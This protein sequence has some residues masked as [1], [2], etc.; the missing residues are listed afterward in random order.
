MQITNKSKKHIKILLTGGHAATAALATILEIKKRASFS[1][2][3]IIWIGTK[4]AME[5][6]KSLTLEARIFPNYGVKFHHLISGRL[7]RRFTVWSIPSL[8]KVPVGFIHAFVLLLRI[9]PAIVVSFGGFSSFPVVV[10]SKFLRKKVIIHDQTTR[11]GKAN[12]MSARFADRVAISFPSSRKYFPRLKT[13]LTGNPVLPSVFVASKSKSDSK[14]IYI[15]GGSRGAQP[16]N[17]ALLP[18]LKKLL[19]KYRV[20]HQTGD[21]DFDVFRK[22]K[23]SLSR[24]LSN[25]YKVMAFADPLQ[26]QSSNFAASKLVV[27]RGGANTVSELLVLGKLSVIIPIPWSYRSEQEGNARFLSSYIKTR[28]IN[29]NDLTPE[30]LYKNIESVMKEKRVKINKPIPGFVF[31]GSLNL[32]NLI[33]ELITAFKKTPGFQPGDVADSKS[34]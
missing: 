34:L 8:L 7:Q 1:D 2:S 20:I 14:A 3:E 5:G 32:V 26:E 24:N 6:S 33:E 12:E 15:T 25:R 28:I 16:I 23:Q 29:Q 22:F 17:Q 30:L 10:V 11:A 21:E 4:Y 13:V 19:M 18:I 31:K 27:A 9:N